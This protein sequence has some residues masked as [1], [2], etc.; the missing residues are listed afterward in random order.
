MLICVPYYATNIAYNPSATV[1]PISASLLGSASL[2]KLVEG[3]VDDAPIEVALPFTLS[4]LGGRYTR[5]YVGPNSY[6]TFGSGAPSYMGLSATMPAIPGIHISGAD[7]SVQ[8]LYAGTEG[9][10]FRIR[11]EGT[12]ATAGVPG[13]PT[14]VWEITFH[15]ITQQFVDVVVG[16]NAR[17]D[18][19]TAG[20]TTG[21][22]D[23][24][25]V[26][27]G[28]SNVAYRYTCA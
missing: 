13:S 22:T 16:D 23:W 1:M 21:T 20:I 27:A 25:A 19:G 12:A 10:T 5:V 6:V 3:N 15:R 8:R 17:G 24:L 11:Y 9:D 4:I 2:T 28:T 7:N 26:P 14:M 18:A